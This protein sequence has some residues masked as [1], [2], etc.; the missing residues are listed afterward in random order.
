MGKEKDP[1]YWHNKGQEDGA[2]N[3]YNEP[4]KNTMPILGELL[5][6]PTEQDKED[7]ED[8]KEGWRNGYD[9]THKSS[10]FITTACVMSEGLAD[11]CEE[12][13]EMRCFRDEYVSGLPNG[14]AMIAEYYATA[15]TIVKAI[16]ASINSESEWV[17]IYK[18]I[19]SIIC[20]IRADDPAG[21]VTSYRDMISRLRAEYTNC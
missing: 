3:D 21:A 1:N 16:N 10:C 17:K 11:N 15:P 2:K 20:L 7:R 4:H 19:S 14:Q 9:S 5:D 12:L 18:E 8:Y 13:T 6:D